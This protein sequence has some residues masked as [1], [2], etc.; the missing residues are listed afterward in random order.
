MVSS[1]QSMNALGVSLQIGPFTGFYAGG[2]GGAVTIK[3]GT[4]GY[5]W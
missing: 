4:P 3:I 2:G 1:V 5:R